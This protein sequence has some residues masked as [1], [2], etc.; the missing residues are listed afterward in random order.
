MPAKPDDLLDIRTLRM[1]R[2]VADLHIFDQPTTKRAHGQLLCKRTAP[3]G[4]G[5]WSRGWS[6]QGSEQSPPTNPLVLDNRCL[7]HRIAAKRFSPIAIDRDRGTPH[8][9]APP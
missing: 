8:G 5:T 3:H 2:Q 9:A 4:A 7:N 6:C 1:P